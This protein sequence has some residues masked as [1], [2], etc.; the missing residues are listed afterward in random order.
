MG[1][2][3]NRFSF[4][5]K[6]SGSSSESSLTS[7]IEVIDAIVYYHNISILHSPIMPD[8]IFL[9]GL[10]IEHCN[11]HWPHTGHGEQHHLITPKVS[12]EQ[13]VK[14]LSKRQ[15]RG[16]PSGLLRLLPQP[17][18]HNDSTMTKTCFSGPAGGGLPWRRP[19]FSWS[20]CW[21]N[22]WP[23]SKWQCTPTKTF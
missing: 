14:I 1:R 6:N 16:P 20:T 10:R 22:R 8:S 2:Q 23:P 15:R 9:H 17:Q 5:G 12:S 19:P 7:S 21:E 4:T 13:Q 3:F 11:L 18:H